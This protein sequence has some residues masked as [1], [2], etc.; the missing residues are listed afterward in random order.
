[1][2]LL[3]LH[4]FTLC[5]VIFRYFIAYY[6]TFRQVDKLLPHFTVGTALCLRTCNIILLLVSISSPAKAEL[7]WLGEEI[8]HQKQ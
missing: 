1:M 6:S 5:Y 8:I 2:M 3:L 7:R 4:Y